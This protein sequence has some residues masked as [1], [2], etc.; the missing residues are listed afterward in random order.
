MGHVQLDHVEAGTLGVFH[1]GD[2]IIDHLVHVLERRFPGHGAVLEIRQ[3]RRRDELPATLRQRF[4]D[5][6]IPGLAGRSLAPGVPDLC[7]KLRM[8]VVMHEADDAFPF[9][10]LVVVPQPGAAR[11]DP[12]CGRGADHLRVDQAGTADPAF[13]VM[14][15]MPVG[16]IAVLGTV[17]AHRRHLEAVFDAH[18]PN[19]EG[20]EYRHGRVF[21]IDIIET[22]IG[23]G[24]FGKPAIDV[25]NVIRIPQAKVLVGNALGTAH[26]VERE[27][28][29]ALAVGVT[30]DVLEPAQGDDGGA[31]QAVRFVLA[32][33]LVLLERGI[34]VVAGLCEIGR[35]GDRILHRELGSRTDTEMR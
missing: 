8:T 20:L 4:V 29:R 13:P 15:E 11:R 5:A 17:L 22:R 21:R 1:R 23:F 30:V 24:V 7:T 35:Q 28:F 34:D 12:A 31:L 18:V 3:G 19:L 32:D 25:I 9:F 14:H 33:A 26:H 10:R 2:E 27:L 6:A 16:G